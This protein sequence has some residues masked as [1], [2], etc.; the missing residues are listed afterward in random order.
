MIT[1]P[2]D[3]RSNSSDNDNNNDNNDKLMIR[4]AYIGSDKACPSPS[5]ACVRAPR[6]CDQSSRGNYGQFS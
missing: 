5:G 3:S 4:L 1:T 2:N 6:R